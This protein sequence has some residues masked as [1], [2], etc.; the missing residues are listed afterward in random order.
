MS[1][2]RCPTC[3]AA[4]G[5]N[6]REGQKVTCSQC[7]FV[8]KIHYSLAHQMRDPVG[9]LLRDPKYVRKGLRIIFVIVLIIMTVI[10]YFEWCY[11]A[12]S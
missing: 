1:S 12:T 11:S 4:L 9:L 3:H 6:Y 2:I 5:D 7:G 10:F 8:I